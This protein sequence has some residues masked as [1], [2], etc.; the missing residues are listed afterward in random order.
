MLELE[1]GSKRSEGR[2]DKTVCSFLRESIK[3]DSDLS[4]VDSKLETDKKSV[5]EAHK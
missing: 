2:V 1:E 5:G 4:L 3:F